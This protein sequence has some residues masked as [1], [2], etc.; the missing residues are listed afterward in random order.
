MKDYTKYVSTLVCLFFSLVSLNATASLIPG[1]LEITGNVS[2]GVDSVATAGGATQ[3]ATLE[4]I[5]GGSP[6][7]SSVNNL[8]VTGSNPQGGL[9]QNINDGV[10]AEVS[11]FGGANSSAE[12]FFFDFLFSLTNTSVTDSFQV[13]FELVF[14][15]TTSA[16]GDDVFA[17]AEIVFENEMNDEIF[18]SDLTSDT[19]FGDEKNGNALPSSGATLTDSGTFLFDF[20]LAANG[21]TS[22]SG[23]I[24]LEAE[25]FGGDGAFSADT[26]AFVRVVGAENITPPVNNVP[27]PPTL[28]VL[29]LAMMYFAVRHKSIKE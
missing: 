8:A 16:S 13:F 24:K 6:S 28:P 18:F 5:L 26:L 1:E 27:S 17:D 11:I 23:E 9:L 19:A 29:I 10:G 21:S 3:T 15:N 7:T 22:F 14:T 25:D 12:D 20:I 2:F 4:S